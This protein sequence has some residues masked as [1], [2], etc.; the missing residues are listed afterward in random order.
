MSSSRKHCKVTVSPTLAAIKVVSWR[1]DLLWRVVMADNEK[2]SKNSKKSS[3]C[4]SIKTTTAML[5]IFIS[6]QS[7]LTWIPQA[8]TR[9]VQSS[10]QRCHH[11]HNVLANGEKPH[12]LSTLKGGL[13]LIGWK[14][15]T[16]NVLFLET[17]YVHW[18]AYKQ[19][20][21]LIAWDKVKYKN[22]QCF[23]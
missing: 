3:S 9:E 20:F 8:K 17:V 19:L 11:D 5:D 22:N 23:Q 15:V 2:K 7:K 21:S 6:I 12:T 4:Q 18:A 13:H 10:L 1:T 16:P 14:E